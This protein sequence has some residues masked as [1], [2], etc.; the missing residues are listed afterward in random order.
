MH[1]ALDAN[2]AAGVGYCKERCPVD[3]IAIRQT[4]PMRASMHEYYL[5]EKRL[6]LTVN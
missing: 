3:A 2:R 1:V 5:E 4:M 6:D